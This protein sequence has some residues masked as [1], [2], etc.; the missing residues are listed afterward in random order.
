MFLVKLSLGQYCDHVYVRNDWYTYRRACW[1]KVIRRNVCWPRFQAFP[2]VPTHIWNEAT[3]RVSYA[4][5]CVYGKRE[6]H[7]L[8]GDWYNCFHV[9]CAFF[10]FQRA[11][12]RR[13]HVNVFSGGVR[14]WKESSGRHLSSTCG[15][16]KECTCIC[17]VYS[18]I[19]VS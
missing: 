12:S 19:R 6:C 14:R 13:S 2:V 10:K 9:L 7:R 15:S 11:T 3:V 4:A 5:P 1:S 8:Y 16:V 17:S 18:A